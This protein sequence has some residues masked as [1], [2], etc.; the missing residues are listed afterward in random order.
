MLLACFDAT[1]TL[2]TDNVEIHLVRIF[3]SEREIPKT[4]I[5][6][7]HIRIP[8]EYTIQRLVGELMIIEA[9]SQ[10]SKFGVQDC[11]KDVLISLCQRRN[12][13]FLQVPDRLFKYGTTFGQLLR[14]TVKSVTTQRR[15]ERYIHSFG[16]ACA[17]NECRCSPDMLVKVPIS[18]A[19][20]Y[21]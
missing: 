12:S 17:K 8:I 18:R 5:V 19:S 10:L 13:G 14:P 3:L 9:T 20:I 4:S 15:T 2:E 6:V 11:L 7:L 16:N 1:S 21:H